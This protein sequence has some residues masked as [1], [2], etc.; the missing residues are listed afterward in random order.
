MEKALI[1]IDCQYDFLKG[2][3]TYECAMLDNALVSRIKKLIYACREKNIPVIYTQHS[4]NSDK[5]NAEFGEPVDVKACIIG[6]RGWEIIKELEPR[7]SE[8]V[9]AKDKYDAF[10][11]TNLEDALAKI[12]PETLI[13]AGVLTNN[14]VRATAEGAHYRGYKLEIVS[15]C[16]GATSFSD[17]VTDEE[18]NRLSLESMAERMYETTLINANELS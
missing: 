6:T 12:R 10:Y 7:N 13:L 16:C 2:A 1:V 15:D 17:G 18:I 5:S 9:V 11:N 4:I 8:A 14:C 3:S